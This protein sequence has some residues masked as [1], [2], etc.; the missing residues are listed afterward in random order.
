MRRQ[1][2]SQMGRSSFALAPVTA[3][4]PAVEIGM[5][6]DQYIWSYFKEGA[7]PQLHIDYKI[8]PDEPPLDT[9]VKDEIREYT[10]NQIKKREPLITFN[11]TSSAI[12]DAPARNEDPK[13]REYQGQECARFYGLPAP[14]IGF[15]VTQWGSGI[16]E[17]ARLTWRTG[18][19]QHV[20]RFL[21]PLAYRTLNPGSR[22]V[23]D[24]TEL[25]R[26]D[27]QAVKEMIES[28][29]GDAQR[30]GIGTMDEARHIAGLSREYEGKLLDGAP[31]KQKTAL[32][33]PA[34]PP[35]E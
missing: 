24:V 33:S 4:R 20:G 18:V 28:I 19:S 21:A 23:V 10:H 12:M 31:Q 27:A 29:R 15:M 34:D 8:G 2:L 16:S 32:P 1:S 9:K 13:H 14:I 5:R 17:L 30:P 3:L 22:F 6:G 26:G 11:A 25:L 35:M 7:K